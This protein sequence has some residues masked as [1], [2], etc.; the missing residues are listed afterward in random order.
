VIPT[1]ISQAL[2][3]RRIELGS[4]SPVRDFLYVADNARGFLAAA[5]ADGVLGEVV[6]LGTGTGVTIGHVVELIEKRMGKSLEVVARP[7]RRRPDKSE[8]LELIC[9]AD[10]AR[11]QMGWQPRVSLEDGLDRTIDAIDTHLHLYRPEQYAV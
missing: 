10:K 7:Q 1:I 6:N 8:V 5:E 2:V 11:R 3:G 9:S 4:T